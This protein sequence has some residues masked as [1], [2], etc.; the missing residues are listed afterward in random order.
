MNPLQHSALAL[1]LS[2]AIAGL[3]ATDLQA[4]EAE[5][6]SQPRHITADPVVSLTFRG[7]TLREFVEALREA[8]DDINI[9][10]PGTA[11]DVPMPRMVLTKTSVESAL[12]SAGVITGGD[13]KLRVETLR[14]HESRPVYAVDVETRRRRSANEAKP[15][16]VQSGPKMVNVFSLAF[17]TS[18]A[19]NEDA[20]LTVDADTVLTA[21]ETGLMVGGGDSAPTMKFHADS[22]LLFVE[23]TIQEMNLV[24]SIISNLESDLRR[25]RSAAMAMKITEQNKSSKGGEIR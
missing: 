17:L 5:Q 10:I 2:T 16:G 7:G 22:G 19:A 4:Q 6:S 1:G 20:S 8:G 21:V 18:A 15:A 13:F 9:V 25:K 24:Q 14:G 3:F 11:D 23:G 12:R